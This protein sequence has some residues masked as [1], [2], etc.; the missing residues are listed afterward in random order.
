MAIDKARFDDL[1][2]QAR[3]ELV[4][5]PLW[6]Q[7]LPETDVRFFEQL[8]P[9]E[10]LRERFIRVLIR[11]SE[12]DK[13]GWESLSLIAQNLL[14]KRE[15]LTPVLADWLADVLEDT[16]GRPVTRGRPP[17]DPLLAVLIA[18]MMQIIADQCGLN[19]TRNLTKNVGAQR[20]LY[21]PK[22]CFEGGSAGDVVGVALAGL[23]HERDFT[24]IADAWRK[25]GPKRGKPSD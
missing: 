24:A 23:G 12:T 18:R 11:H 8:T 14:R 21:L 2:E 15:P 25:H 20:Q 4:G 10:E 5:T 17:Q 13:R 1:V 9:S 6:G 16:K 7:T 19:P 3:R 22:P